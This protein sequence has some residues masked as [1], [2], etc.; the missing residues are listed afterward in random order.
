MIGPCVIGAGNRRSESR[1]SMRSARVALVALK[2][3]RE[4]VEASLDDVGCCS[5][6]GI[7]NQ[8]PDFAMRRVPTEFQSRRL[9]AGTGGKMRESF[10]AVENLV[11]RCFQV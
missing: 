4:N 5:T 11:N 3:V 9:E 2:L 8:P 6:E 7:V 1:H 10:D